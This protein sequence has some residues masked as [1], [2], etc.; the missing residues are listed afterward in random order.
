MTSSDTDV[1][2]D[3]GSGLY[4]FGVDNYGSKDTPIVGS[5]IAAFQGELPISAAPH[6]I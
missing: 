5:Q 4:H 3:I 2:A 1:D 6:S